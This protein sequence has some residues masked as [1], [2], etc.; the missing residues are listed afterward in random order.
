M[1]RIAVAGFL[2]E[3][4]SFAPGLTDISAFEVADAWPGM[5]VGD[6][7]FGGFGQANIATAGFL[8]AAQER[9]WDIAP[10]LWC[11]A[12]PSGVVKNET[13]ET[14]VAD[15][16][17]RLEQTMPVD[18][19]FLD[20]HGAMVS[21][22]ENDADGELLAR[23]RTIVGS[24]IPIVTALDFHANIS[25]RMAASVDRL[26]IYQT[27]PHVDIADTGRRA[28]GYLA[29][30]LT[31]QR[32]EKVQ[33]SVPFLLPL[34]TQSTL[35]GPMAEVMAAMRKLAREADATVELAAG[36]PLADAYETGP[37][38][39]AYAPDGTSAEAVVRH[40]TEILV[41]RENDF[42]LQ[43]MS[44]CEAVAAAQKGG[45]GQ[46]T[47][48]LIDTQDNPGG[49]ATG[50][51][52]GLLRALIE[53]GCRKAVMGVLFDPET[54][55]Q[56]HKV[57][58]GGDFI[59][60][61][62]A[63][64]CLGLEL[65]LRGRAK[66]VAV[67]DGNFIGTGSFYRGCRFALGPMA[68]LDISG[69]RVVVSSVRQQAADQ[70]MFRHVGVE[71]GETKILALKSSVHYRADFDAI[72]HSTIIVKSPGLNTANPADLVYRNLRHPMRVAGGDLVK[73][74]AI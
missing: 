37:A 72:A 66:V 10:L 1:T 41:T 58:I 27:Y 8:I 68:C 43:M 55:L 3:T 64:P 56:A 46:G 29:D 38:V 16:M 11:S 12:G 60:F 32:H 31:G 2:H 24:D 17:Q 57:G 65:P 54:V 48:L 42:K 4:N 51:T 19:V 14:V 18:A 26:A 63:K 36:F 62:G 20:L 71:P 35:D 9:G 61:V 52:V 28:A 53:G 70:A 25:A 5:L 33:R 13:F 74:E 22:S 50:D 7:L 30:L 49:G 6:A 44:P 47:T 34:G 59:A 21:E 45:A 73:R 67:G 69:V 23:V 39:V 15:M 40:A